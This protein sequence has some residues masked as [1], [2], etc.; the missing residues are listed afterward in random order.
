MSRCI[1]V[2]LPYVHAQS[3]KTKWPTRAEQA[4]NVSLTN[5]PFLKKTPFLNRFN[6]A[7]ILSL[8]Q[9]T[10][11]WENKQRTHA[12]T[13]THRTSTVTRAAHVHRGL[14]THGD[15]TLNIIAHGLWNFI[16]KTFF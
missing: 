13:H 1:E 14:I 11:Q 4:N 8:T 5:E 12:H 3:R 2:G 9:H 16:L 10:A 6:D 15:A 7:S